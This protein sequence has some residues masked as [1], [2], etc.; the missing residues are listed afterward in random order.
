MAL[1]SD[2]KRSGQ[3]LLIDSMN[4]KNYLFYYF[5]AFTWTSKERVQNKLY[6]SGFTA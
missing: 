5:V 4:V 6:H 3:S 1:W 2:K